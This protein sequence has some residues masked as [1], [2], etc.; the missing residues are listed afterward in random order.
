[1]V[2]E[3]AWADEMLIWLYI[4]GDLTITV[5]ENFTLNLKWDSIKKIFEESYNDQSWD[6]YNSYKKLVC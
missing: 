6:S 4:L 2:A 1:M 5:I 3:V